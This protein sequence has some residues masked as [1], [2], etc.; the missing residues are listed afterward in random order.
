MDNE[1]EKFLVTLE[2]IK[3]INPTLVKSVQSATS[4]IFNYEYFE[5]AS[6]GRALVD[7][8]K[9]ASEPVKNVIKGLGDTPVKKVAD[10]ISPTKKVAD[11]IEVPGKKS[12][13]DIKKP[14]K[15]KLKKAG[16]AALAGAGIGSAMDLLDG[17][18]SDD[19]ESEDK[20][21]DY[22][23]KPDRSGRFWPTNF[24]TG[25][26]NPEQTQEIDKYA[27]FG[28]NKI[29]EK[30]LNILDDIS[31]LDEEEMKDAAKRYAEVYEYWSNIYRY[32][33]TQAFDDQMD[34]SA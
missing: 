31:N 10:D 29:D 32:D 26:L 25:D 17:D 34:K 7:V 28:P 8:L 22:V 18:N 30:L 11:D 5:E 3:D 19:S 15:S 24:H 27:L 33:M 9:K 21:S 6:G 16:T 1:V 12:L 23:A 4:E 2:S 20:I 14:K 13:D